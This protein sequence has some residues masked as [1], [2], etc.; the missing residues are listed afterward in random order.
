MILPDASLTAPPYFAL[1]VAGGSGLRMGAAVPKQFLLLGGEPVLLR[2]LRRFAQAV[3]A[4]RRLVVLP[5]AEH[6]RWHAQLREGAE[7][8]PHQVVTGGATRLASVRNGLA[9]ITALG[10]PDTALVAVHDGVRPLVPVSVLEEAFRV[11]AA[12]G[13][14]VAAVTLKD[15]VR[16][17]QPDG[18]STAEDR[19]AFRL[20]QTPQCFP[21]GL[22]R[23]AYAAVADDDPALTD[24]ASVVERFGRPVTLI[25]GH[26]ENLKLTTP[27]DLLIAEVLW[28]RQNS[29]GGS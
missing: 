25:A 29:G 24:D 28:Q 10:A 19:A 9:A 22:L 14:A 2:T 13:S 15:S 26:P 3:P 12:R 11:A 1:I 23:A 7:V 18:S 27:D 8:P 5:A 20:I 21:L 4:A 17:V 6:P 16:R